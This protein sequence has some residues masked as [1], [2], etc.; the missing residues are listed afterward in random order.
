M[1]D[2]SHGV[3]LY[4]THYGSNSLSTRSSF[5]GVHTRVQIQ[6]MYVITRY[7]V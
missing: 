4:I 7:G 3:A 2:S 1:P 5:R 6:G